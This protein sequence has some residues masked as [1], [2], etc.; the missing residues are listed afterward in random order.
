MVLA[1]SH[2]GSLLATGYRDG[3]CDVWKVP[4]LE[5]CAVFPI[6]KGAGSMVLRSVRRENA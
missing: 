2:D 5:Q 1:V 3:S 4:W 6:M